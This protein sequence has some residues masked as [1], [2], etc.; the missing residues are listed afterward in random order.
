MSNHPFN[1]VLGSYLA[2]RRLFPM[3]SFEHLLKF[4][5]PAVINTY[6]NI[7]TLLSGI[8][9]NFVIENVHTSPDEC[10]NQ[11]AHELGLNVT[12]AIKGDIVLRTDEE[13]Q[14][15][16]RVRT[17]LARLPL[18][19]GRSF[20]SSPLDTDPYPVTGSFIVRG[21]SRTV[22]RTKAVGFDRAIVLRK[23]HAIYLQVRSRHPKK[24]F[25]ST[26]TIDFHI[27]L[28]SKR[29]KD[30]GVISCRLA[31]QTRLVHVFVIARALGASVTQ[32][33]A[34]IRAFAGARYKG[35]IFRRYELS[36]GN[37]ASSARCKT[38]LEAEMIISNIYGKQLQS[39]GHGIIARETF[40]HIT[41]PEHPEKEKRF[42]LMFLGQC[43]AQLIMLKHKLIS[44]DE[45]IER[46][47]FSMAHIQT[48]AN[49]V[50]SL[51]RLL[52]I[53]HI[54]T[55]GKLLRRAL[56]KLK[57]TAFA[58][59][60]KLDLAKVFGEARLSARL[61]SAIASGVWSP[62]RK[63]I[64]I[65][66]NTNNEDAITTQLRRMSSSLTTTDGVNVTPRQ[67]PKD[68]FGDV[69]ASFTPDGDATGLVFEMG[70]LSTITPP[71]E[72]RYI[73]HQIILFEMKD[74]MQDITKHFNDPNILPAN[75]RFYK[76]ATG[77]ISHI[78]TDYKAFIVRFRRLRR[79]G[80][81][82]PFAAVSM[83][84]PMLMLHVELDEGMI[85]RPLVIAKHWREIT[86]ETT[87]H[88]AVRN[89]W[90]EYISTRERMSLCFIAVGL[91]DV[92]DETTHIELTQAALL[93]EMASSPPFVTSQQ[94]PRNTYF[95]QQRKQKITANYKN[96]L[97]SIS[98]TQLWHAH[99]PL[100]Q[101][102]TAKMLPG[103]GY[104]RGTPLVIAFM[105][106]PGV[107]E[108]AVI[109]KKSAVERGAM[110]A[111]TTRT[112]M[113]EA[114][115]RS[116]VFEEKFE[117]VT[118]SSMQKNAK[119]DGVELNGL[120]RCGTFIEGGDVVI[121]KTRSMRRPLGCSKG[122][123]QRMI[124]SRRDIS[125][126]S[127]PDESGRVTHSSLSK[128]PTGTRATV[129]IETNRLPIPGD[130]ITTSY[131]QKAIIAELWPEEDLPFNENGTPDFIASPLSLT[132]RMTMGS[133][134][135]ALTGKAVAATANR[136]IGIDPQQFDISNKIHVK[137]VEDLLRE[138]GLSPSGKEQYY[139]G[140]T[141]KPL[142]GLVFTGIIDVF[143][144]VH[145]AAKKV[146]G[147]STGPRHLV[148][149]Q[150]VEG[151]RA[152]GGLRLSDMESS[153]V[154]GHGAANVHVERFRD[155][156]D[157]FMVYICKG[158]QIFVDF[159]N[160]MMNYFYCKNCN[161][162]ELIRQVR[163]SFTLRVVLLEMLSIGVEI[164]LEL[165]DVED[166]PGKYVSHISVNDKKK[167]S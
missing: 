5:I 59:L 124:I 145:L 54:R 110:A 80:H 167:R 64:S 65:A 152:G 95:G 137:K 102:L 129:T 86:L 78:V 121:A 149:R 103:H 74:I 157:N 131:S 51:F 84:E 85:C 66:L 120:P 99:R 68:Q 96:R 127:R 37:N 150:P 15:V 48:S 164:K 140:R 87:F 77:D 135:E 159:N 56:M 3:H 81:I 16:Y 83:Y 76:S 41:Y 155:L 10:D 22:P 53:S 151:R 139:D 67:I 1:G 144:L 148:T 123:P 153:A 17:V 50:G 138:A 71:I 104:G 105:A 93:G 133:M 111:S 161:S 91:A 166:G 156:A 32:F 92:T 34:I 112:Y 24:P 165:T 109:L 113:S 42:K 57:G 118:S 23:K 7:T 115:Q 47:H 122:G 82:S 35:Y 143:R 107:E 97:G 55:C 9:Y 75:H 126:L 69:C 160:P 8:K 146:H 61:M 79:G 43:C 62:L 52:F 101:P 90:V 134:L 132:S 4:D 2:R 13:N 108:D 70:I 58:K 89:G 94:G 11:S 88:D 33:N 114:P 128:L 29:P 49:H 162:R 38:Q 45:I 158:C 100:V 125:T 72:D 6:G 136:D 141:G 21:K 12:V 39:T 98:T 18:M 60:A 28:Q 130:K 26:S 20:L 147:R 30:E 40:P 117:K 14:F 106:I 142:A 44:D 19:T 46:D 154:L 119:Y 36:M 63:G 31:F 25:R 73:L 27:V 163:I 116:H